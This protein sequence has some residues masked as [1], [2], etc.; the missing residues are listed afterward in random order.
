[1]LPLKRP[2]GLNADCTTAFI[3][4]RTERSGSAIRTPFGAWF[5]TQLTDVE[6]ERNGIYFYDRS[7]KFDMERIRRIFSIAP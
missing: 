3:A 1:V 2:L 5:H 7:E 6:Q 4:R